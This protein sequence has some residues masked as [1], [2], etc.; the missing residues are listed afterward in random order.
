MVWHSAL[1]EANR[2]ATERV[3]KVAIKIILGED[4]ESYGQALELTGLETLENRRRELCK[5]FAKNCLKNPKTNNMFPRKPSSGHDTRAPEKFI[6]QK[7]RTDTLRLS[8][9]PYMQRL[10]NQQ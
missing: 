9:I 1:T 5:R 4:Y 10:L 6:V 8:S 2:Y 7:A 3:Q